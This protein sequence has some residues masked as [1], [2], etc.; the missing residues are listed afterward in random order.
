MAIRCE[1][2]VAPARQCRE[3]EFASRT[4]ENEKPVVS[5][6]ALIRQLS[7]AP[8]EEG[9]VQLALSQFMFYEINWI[10]SSVG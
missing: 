2:A 8:F 7:N 6:R 5:E 4:V 1:H 10:Q 9:I 3:V